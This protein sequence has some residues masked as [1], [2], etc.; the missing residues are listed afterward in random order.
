MSVRIFLL[1]RQLTLEYPTLYFF[2]SLADLLSF[3]FFF[4]RRY[5]WMSCYL[6]GDTL[7]SVS[8]SSSAA[9]PGCY[10]L[11]IRRCFHL[12][13]K[14]FNSF[15]NLIIWL[16]HVLQPWNLI[17]HCTKPLL[18]LVSCSLLMLYRGCCASWTLLSWVSVACVRPQGGDHWP[19]QLLLL[20][21]RQAL[22]IKR[23]M[24]FITVDA[25]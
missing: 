20:I 17:L 14:S 10:C 18:V 25:I 24:P 13:P 4:S 9:S 8:S 23:S 12:L 16:I 3:I 19:R 5:S 1:T 11:F 22:F 6:S 21:W 15:H 7:S 2:C